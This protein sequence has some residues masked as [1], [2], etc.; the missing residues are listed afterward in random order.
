MPDAGITELEH[1]L[2]RHLDTRVKVDLKGPRG[3]V[4]VEFAD[5]DDLER[6]YRAVTGAP[7]S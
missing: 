4:I 3:R 1:L 6:I 2:E 7:S 5:L